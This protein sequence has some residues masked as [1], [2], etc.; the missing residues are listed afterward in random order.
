[1]K[2]QALDA[3]ARCFVLM[4]GSAAEERVAP[5]PRTS[6]CMRELKKRRYSTTSFEM[7]GAM[8]GMHATRVW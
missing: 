2:L 4:F 6:C 1:M 3:S 8:E 5:A 7:S